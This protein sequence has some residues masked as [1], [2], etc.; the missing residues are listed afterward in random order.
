MTGDPDSN[1][2]GNPNSAGRA[3]FPSLGLA[4]LIAGA[5]MPV[6]A[7]LAAITGGLEAAA[8]IP[9]IA[10]FLFPFNIVFFALLAMAVICGIFAIR[11]PGSGRVLGW[12][13]LILGGVQLIAAVAYLVWSGTDILFGG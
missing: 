12:I 11:N 1:A 7:I 5:V 13:G 4:S 3:S 2:N 6:W 10:L 9:V 8:W